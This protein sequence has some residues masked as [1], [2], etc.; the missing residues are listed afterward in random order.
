V[1]NS[2]AANYGAMSIPSGGSSVVNERTWCPAA[3][4]TRGIPPCSAVTPRETSGKAKWAP[5][6][7][8]TMSQLLMSS[9][10]PP[11]QIPFTAAMSGLVSVR[12]REM[13]AKPE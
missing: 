3:A 12:R 13:A 2:S 5:S 10:P 9:V 6:H 8:T 4:T 7:A 11:K 1:S